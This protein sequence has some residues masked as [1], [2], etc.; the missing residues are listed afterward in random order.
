M[1][2]IALIRSSRDDQDGVSSG[3]SGMTL[4][5]VSGVTSSGRKARDWDY[6]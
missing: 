3:I 2:T 1:F 4:D 5:V 6:L